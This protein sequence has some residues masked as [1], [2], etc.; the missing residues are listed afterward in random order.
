MPAIRKYA[1]H[2]QRQAAYRRRTADAL[3]CTLAARGLPTVSPIPTIPSY[4]RWDAMTRQALALLNDTLAEMQDY[5][6]DRSDEWQETERAQELAERIDALQAIAD[7]L[8]ELVV[9]EV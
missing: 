4:R 5:A 3:R 1:S 7:T 8:Q 2:A 6:G 9:A